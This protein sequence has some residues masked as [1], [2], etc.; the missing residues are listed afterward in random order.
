MGT[1]HLYMLAIMPPRELMKDIEKIRHQFAEKY[2]CKA[3]LKPPVHITIIPPYK[4]TAETEDL[5]A[6]ALEDWGRQHI[7]FPVT[8]E[9]FG[10]FRKNGVVY[11]NITS[12]DLLQLFQSDLER[13]FKSLIPQAASGH[14]PYHP[15]ITIGYRD[16]PPQVFP[17][18]A[19]E[20]LS[21]KFFATFVTDKFYLWKHNTHKWEVLYTFTIGN[22]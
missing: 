9:N 12:N 14:R 20:Y 22:M 2:N 4:A 3:A 6:P 16:I 11:I 10:T 7:P 13:K 1:E 5:L 17:A 21:K 15:H 19:H 8:L 18:A